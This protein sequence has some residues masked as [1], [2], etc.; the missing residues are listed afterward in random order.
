MVDCPHRE[1]MGYGGDAHATTETGPEQLPPGGVLHEMGPGLARRA[2]QRRGLGQRRQGRSARRGRRRGGRQPA[3]HRADLL[4]RRRT[5]LVRLLHHAALAIYRHYGDVRIL[6]EASPPLSAGWP[7][8]RASEGRHAGPMGWRVGFPGRLALAGREGRQR[9]HA[10]YAR[11]S[12]TATGSHNL[13]TAARIADVLGRGPA[14]GRLPPAGRCGPPRRSTARSSDPQRQD[15]V[16]GMP[17]YLA[18]G[19][20]GRSA[21]GRTC[22]R[23]SGSSLKTRSWSIAKG[24]FTRALPAATSSNRSAL[25]TARI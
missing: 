5:G 24:T 16:S 3:L 7:S 11:S 13:E 15:Y 14:A 23:P 1:R 10:R 19:P 2:R 20:A 18:I 6:E 4:G 22:G 17:A 9:R 8:S 12:T 21:A 25:S